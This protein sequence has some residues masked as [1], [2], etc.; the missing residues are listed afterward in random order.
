MPRKSLQGRTCGVSCE[1]G[2]AR[3]LQPSRRPVALQPICP[4]CTGLGKT[5]PKQS[6]LRTVA[7]SRREK[8]LGSKSPVSR[9]RDAITT[10]GTGR[11]PAH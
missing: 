3:T 7:A 4:H 10:H 8:S 11:T 6:R 2:R 9:R 5:M 1:G